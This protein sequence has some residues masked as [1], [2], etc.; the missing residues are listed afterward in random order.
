M[1]SD[2]NEKDRLPVPTQLVEIRSERYAIADSGGD[3]PAI[4]LA[5]GW[6]DRKELWREV[7]PVLVG[8]GYRVIAFDWLAHGESSTPASV[9][10]CKI[11][12]LAADTV[13]I[14]DAL[15]VRQAILVAHD[16]GATVSW[17]TVVLYP[18]RFLAFVAVS[19]GHSAQIARDMLTG[20]F[21]HYYWLTLHG[22]K[23]LSRTW[24]L[25]SNARRFHEK[26]ASHVDADHILKKLRSGDAERFW[27]IWERANPSYEVTARH[28]L[29]GFRKRSVRCPTLGIY[30]LHDEWMTEGQ[31]KNSGRHVDG[32]WT[33]RTIDSAH[34]VPLE[35]P[36]ELCRLITD[37][38][39]AENLTQKQSEKRNLPIKAER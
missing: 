31:M 24:Y 17:E 38:L 23:R 11:S 3:G 13:A 2:I 12:E 19:V 32:P 7:W 20:H 14:L 34:W 26:F 37:W 8:A 1:L 15:G 18:D 9:S 30:T 16:Y 35:K 5:H 33:Y 22:M 39:A 29:A 4:I 36:V 28:F 6:P 25:A 27:T 10:R 21:W